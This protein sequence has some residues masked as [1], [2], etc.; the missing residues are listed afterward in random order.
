MRDGDPY[1]KKFGGESGNDP[2]WFK[3]TIEGFNSDNQST[4]K[5]DVLLADFTD[6][7]NANDYIL[8]TWKWVGLESL[9]RIA[10]LQFSVSSSDNGLWGMNTPAYFCIDN[11]NHETGT[12]AAELQ[13]LQVS[14]YP[15]PFTDFAVVSGIK[16]NAQV[17]LTD[18]N[19]KLIRRYEKISG[20]QIIDN[21]GD[22]RTGIYFLRVS[23]NNR[24]TT[25]KL[26]KK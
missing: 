26:I 24:S 7:N 15:N 23:E 22:L 8:D 11:L 19:G 1:A 3:L 2:D 12:S 6:P 5:I 14:V 20:N 13:K 10:K 16:N 18:I 21:L 25:V 17:M 9:G 4:G